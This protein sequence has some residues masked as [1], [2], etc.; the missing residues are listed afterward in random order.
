L[1]CCRSAGTDTRFSRH[2]EADPWIG[3]AGDQL[4]HGD[5]LVPEAVTLA[6][7]PI[8][9]ALDDEGKKGT[10]GSVSSTF[11]NT[12]DAL[13]IGMGAVAS[14]AGILDWTR[15]DGGAHFEIAAESLSVTAFVT[16]VIKDVSNRSRP[17][18]ASKD[19][20]PSGHMSFA[21]A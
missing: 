21:T 10:S 4:E 19:S 15:G 6:A 11:S 2:F 9:F 3:A 20:F 13:T 16:E 12:T 1:P 8:V 17:T 5:R 7:I 14:A 18:G